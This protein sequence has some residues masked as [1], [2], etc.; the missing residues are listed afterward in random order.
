MFLSDYK[1]NNIFSSFRIKC[2]GKY[3][4]LFFIGNLER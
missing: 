3:Y 4:A 2:Q 1:L